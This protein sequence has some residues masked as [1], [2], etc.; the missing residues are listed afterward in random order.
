MIK[1]DKYLKA[2]IRKQWNNRVKVITGFRR[3][4]KSTLLFDLYK[5]NNGE[6]GTQIAL[7][8]K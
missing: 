4:G 1:R 7:Y 5:L 2:L 8:E 6:I 3:S